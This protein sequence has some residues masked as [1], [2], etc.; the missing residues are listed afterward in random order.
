MERLNE[1][2]HR[3]YVPNRTSQLLCNF[4]DG[5]SNFGG[6]HSSGGFA[7]HALKIVDAHLNSQGVFLAFNSVKSRR[8]LRG[9]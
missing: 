4:E 6:L 9:D 1:V 5:F 7:R 8:W 2:T 3:L